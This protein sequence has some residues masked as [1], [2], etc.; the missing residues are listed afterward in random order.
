MKPRLLVLV[1]A[2]CALAVPVLA[3]NAM[4]YAGQQTRQIKAL[5]D[6]DISAL[7]RGEGMGF[8]KAAELNG[9][10]GP[11]HV[12][13]LAQQLKLTETQRQQVQ[14]IFNR[15]DAAAK[16]LGAELVEHERLLDQLFAKGEITP[17]RLAAETAA[18]EHGDKPPKD[19]QEFQRLCDE[20]ALETPMILE[21][22]RDAFGTISYREM[23]LQ[24]GVN[25]SN[26]VVVQDQYAG[27]DGWRAGADLAQMDF[28]PPISSDPSTRI[29]IAFEL[30]APKGED[31]QEPGDQ[32]VDNQYQQSAVSTGPN[33]KIG[34]FRW[35]GQSYDYAVIAQ[36][37][38]FDGPPG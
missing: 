1:A 23:T 2:A 22:H 18:I 19:P 29:Y 12:L 21:V 30:A 9:Y 27:A 24:Q 31:V 26:W 14:A 17:E 35:N 3:D 10:P 15:M 8:A 37:P 13:T 6:E 11:A 4:P 36:L 33:Q 34:H 28:S 25:S 32:L 7:L 16:P 5:S 38:C 20:L